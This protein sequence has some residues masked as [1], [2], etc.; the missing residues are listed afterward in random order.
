MTFYP[1][2]FKKARKKKKFTAEEVA[3]K[4]GV[5]RRTI[6]TWETARIVPNES[7][8]RMLAKVIDIPVNEISDLE[9]DKP[10]SPIQF[11]EVVNSW[12]E[13][14]ESKSRDKNNR[15]DILISGISSIKQAYNEA[16]LVINA[17]LN[18]ISSI[19]YLKDTNLKYIT[20]N[21][22][23]YKNLSL[24]EGYSVLGK[25]DSNFF[26]S[27]EAGSNKEEDSFVIRTG[28]KILNKEGFIPGTRKKKWGLISKIPVYDDLGNVQGLIGSFVDITERKKTEEMRELFEANLDILQEGITI[29]V[30]NRD[31]SRNIIY[32][33]KANERI[34]E[35]QLDVF[36]EDRSFENWLKYV[37]PDYIEI[38]REFYQTFTWPSKREFKFIT[39]A[40]K[41]KCIEAFCHKLELN[42]REYFFFAERDITDSID[43]KEFIDDLDEAIKV[44]KDV[45]WSGRIDTKVGFIFKYLSKSTE[46]LFN[47][48]IDE[49]R[50]KPLEWI[51][52]IYEADRNNLIDWFN[53]MSSAETIGRIIN[54]TGEIKHCRFK[55]V[56]RGNNF[57]IFI[58]DISKSI[59]IFKK[60]KY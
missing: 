59:E 19:F 14:A 50:N 3:E 37:H 46:E 43:R 22:E 52:F 1:D 38:E 60:T 45:V 40:G 11:S 8:I 17:L 54:K 41:E 47:L 26:I 25:T 42:G 6:S 44:S 13:V 31:K 4:M 16:S 9:E 35:I 57:F 18:S 51:E 15:F 24:K 10:I 56:L 20:A 2:E 39:S 36:M 29:A 27:A 48:T 58:N 33:N 34:Y 12:L 21:K 7:R 5:N 55:K 53:K 30:K 49:L 23:F 28:N 32:A